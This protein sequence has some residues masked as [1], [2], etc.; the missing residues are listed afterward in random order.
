MAGPLNPVQ[1]ERLLHSLAH[2]LHCDPNQL[3]QQLQSGNISG[4]ASSMDG[5]SAKQLQALLKNPRQLQQVM[6]S[7]EM[8]ELL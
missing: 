3:R 2:Q 7:P 8:K 4:I 6:N 5:D 1:M